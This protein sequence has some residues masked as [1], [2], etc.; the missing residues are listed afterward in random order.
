M[1]TKKH[2]RNEDHGIHLLTTAD[3]VEL[4]D[5]ITKA[6]RPFYIDT[7]HEVENG[8]DVWAVNSETGEDY[9]RSWRVMD[10]LSVLI[11]NT[12]RK[13]NSALVGEKSFEDAHELGVW[14]AKEFASL[15]GK[16]EEVPP[17]NERGDSSEDVH[18]SVY[19]RLD[20]S[21][22]F[23][24]DFDTWGSGATGYCHLDNDTVAKAVE[25]G[26][27]PK[28]WAAV[29]DAIDW[30]DFDVCIRD[31]ELEI[32]EVDGYSWESPSQYFEDPGDGGWKV[33]VD[34]G[35]DPVSAATDTLLH[36]FCEEVLVALSGD[37]DYMSY[38]EDDTDSILEKAKKDPEIQKT[39]GELGLD[40][41]VI[42]DLFEMTN[43]DVG[44]EIYNEIM[45]W[46]GYEDE[47]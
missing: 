32:G 9:P 22:W 27:D 16:T 28:L 36:T 14:L 23:S 24:L 39:L 4:A 26:M 21:S 13:G 43:G 18:G 10:D 41:K 31:S 44:Q 15:A 12:D 34:L 17:K 33:T 1:I 46:D 25:K 30:D 2:Q 3:V 20:K 37:T 11:F 6:G 35:Q 40:F 5:S 42:E 45:G 38:S 29:K 19:L 8:L 7:D 47:N